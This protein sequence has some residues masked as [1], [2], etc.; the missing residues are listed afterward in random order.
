[1]LVFLSSNLI[2]HGESLEIYRSFKG[3]Q[4]FLLGACSIHH[5]VRLNV[6]FCLFL[7]AESICHLSGLGYE[8]STDS[9]WKS[10][11]PTVRVLGVEVSK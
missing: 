1:V 2:P 11:I 5:C 3:L 10:A 6:I 7:V 9:E 4:C 8:I